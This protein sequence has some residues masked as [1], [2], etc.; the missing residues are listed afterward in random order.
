M[1]IAQVI[2]NTM[3]HT[4]HD[5]CWICNGVTIWYCCWLVLCCEIRYRVGNT[6]L[7]VCV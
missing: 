3:Y 1:H 2:Y 7:C 4:N 5:V 6:E